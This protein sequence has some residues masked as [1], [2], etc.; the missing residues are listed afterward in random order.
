[1]NNKTLQHL[2]K[3]SIIRTYS[4]DV[5]NYITSEAGE[6]LLMDKSCIDMTE[7]F[8][9]ICDKLEE[10]IALIEIQNGK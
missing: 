1:M 7:R 9:H 4:K 3:I 6:T 2:K 5:I 10:A 8:D